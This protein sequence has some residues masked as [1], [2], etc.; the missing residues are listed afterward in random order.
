[1]RYVLLKHE[2]DGDFH[3]DFLLD[4]GFER[5]LTWQI[6]DNN[7][8]KHLETGENFS[9]FSCLPNRTNDTFFPNCQ[10]IFDHRRK[11]LDFSGDLGDGRGCVSRI[12]CGTWELCG[13]CVKRLVIKTVGTCLADHSTIVRQWQ[14]EP[15]VEIALVPGEPSPDRLMQQLPPPDDGDWVVFCTR[16]Y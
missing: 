8:I 11:Y 5:L 3:V 14:F 6:C 1:M 13:V 16:L 15:P 10:R 2:K 7:L 9:N 12:E 4:C